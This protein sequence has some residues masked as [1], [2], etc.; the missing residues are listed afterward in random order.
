[1]QDL[2]ARKNINKYV[3][4]STVIRGGFFIK[5]LVDNKTSLSVNY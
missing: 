3:E 1:M 5:F 2:F 4:T